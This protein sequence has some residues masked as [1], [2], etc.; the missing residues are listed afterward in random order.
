MTITVDMKTA[1]AMAKR[2]LQELTEGEEIQNVGLEE[3][4]YD[5]KTE[6][7][8]VL[9]GYSRPWDTYKEVPSGAA[10]NAFGGIPTVTRTQRTFK[11]IELD[12][13]GNLVSFKG[14]R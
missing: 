8:E 14:K 10:P 6:R 7:W 1:I 5:D 11:Y 9:L 4:S 3:I 13:D 2:H 12:K